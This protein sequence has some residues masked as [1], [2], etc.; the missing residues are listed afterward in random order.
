[1][2]RALVSGPR[3]LLL[4]EPAGGLTDEELTSLAGVIRSIP[5]RF[6]AAVLLIEHQMKLVMEISNRVCVLD[7]GKT[8][9]EG[10]P[11]Q[12]QNDPAVIQTYLGAKD[13]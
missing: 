2:A 5:D 6:G 10:T 1:M 12:V 13:A 4:D 7:F 9:A 11:H 8:I 3:L